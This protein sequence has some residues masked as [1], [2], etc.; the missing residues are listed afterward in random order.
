M[1]I[2]G[3]ETSC[4]E[5]SAAVVM[6]GK[7]IRSNVV[8]TQIE[9]HRPYYGV[10]PEIASRMHTEWIR[11]V[12]DKSLKEAG[13]EKEE[14]DGVAVTNRPG[15]VGSLLVGL[16]FAKGFAYSL[17]VPLC[18]VNHIEAHLY[19]PHLEYD[20]TYPYVGVIVSGGHTIIAVVKDVDTMEVLGTTID[21]ACGE[22]FDKVAK[23]Y[24]L[25]FPGGV[26]I[27]KLA[28]AGNPDAFSFPFPSLHKGDHTFDVSYSGLKT[29]V[30]NQ[31][32]Q[33]WNKQHEK[34]N[35]NIA[36]AFQKTAIDILVSR[37]EKAVE[38]TGLNTVVLGGGVAANSYLRERVQ[39][40]KDKT[41]IFPSLALCTDNGAMIAGLGYHYLKRGDVA[42]LSINASA[43]VANYRKTYP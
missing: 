35:E 8:A 26:V 14:V 36:A 2:L 21:D 15:L 3:I 29:A 7:T 17:R 6:D 32:D 25:G 31:L 16:S 12:V 37:I 9:I 23:H 18:G 38:Y 22:A 24:K 42:P 39:M 11:A 28:S 27:D 43:R 40:I 41:F 5:C 19:A 1:N 4:D 20:I 10:V 30:I 13:I 33:F 34:S